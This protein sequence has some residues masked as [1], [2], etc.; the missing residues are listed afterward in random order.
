MNLSKIISDLQSNGKRPIV[1]VV[2]RGEELS[3]L[4]Q[5]AY[6][7]HTI[8]HALLSNAIAVNT[9]EI[10]ATEACTRELASYSVLPSDVL[11]VL[12]HQVAPI[13]ENVLA[14]TNN[15]DITTGK[16]TIS[17]YNVLDLV[18]ILLWLHKQSTQGRF[19]NGIPQSMTPLEFVQYEWSEQ[20]RNLGQLDFSQIVMDYVGMKAT[21]YDILYILKESLET[22]DIV[23]SRMI[24]EIYHTIFKTQGLTKEG[25]KFQ[26]TLI[27][28]QIS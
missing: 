11:K 12:G 14:Q 3:A 6:A 18:K 9:H 21:W 26:F 25:I 15:V 22:Q 13:A 20:I 19:W 24:P 4:L 27:T 7:T 1:I 10:T 17:R 16:E 23:L 28:S 8:P 2:E 5:A